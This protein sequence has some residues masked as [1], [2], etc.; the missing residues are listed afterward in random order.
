MVDA[1]LRRYGPV[2]R[3]GLVTCPYLIWRRHESRWLRS[4]ES[5]VPNQVSKKHETGTPIQTD[6]RQRKSEG[7]P[8]KNAPLRRLHTRPESEVIP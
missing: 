4:L 6:T 3:L 8:K 7:V 1:S 2:D 5:S